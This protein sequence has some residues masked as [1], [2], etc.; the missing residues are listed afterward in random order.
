MA[1]HFPTPPA[2][3][4]IASVQYIAVP[5]VPLTYGAFANLTGLTV[6]AGTALGQSLAEGIINVTFS[7]TTPGNPGNFD[8]DGIESGLGSYLNL[9]AQ[10]LALIAAVSLAVVQAHIRVTRTWT[11]TGPAGWSTVS[12]TETVPYP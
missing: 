10:G 3:W 9:M 7:F 12:F 5:T 4:A 6:N 8:Q 1:N 11:L 2:G